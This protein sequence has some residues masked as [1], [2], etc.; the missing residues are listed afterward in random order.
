METNEN[1]DCPP[2]YTPLAMASRD[3]KRKLPGYAIPP[4][5]CGRNYTFGD[6]GAPLTRQPKLDS[7]ARES[8]DSGGWDSED[9]DGWDSEDSDAW[10]S[11]DDDAQNFQYADF[12]K[13]Q[14][15]DSQQPPGVNFQK[16]Q[17]AGPHG[18]QYIDTENPQD[19]GCSDPPRDDEALAR[20]RE[21]ELTKKRNE[22]LARKRNRD[23]FRIKRH[24]FSRFRTAIRD[25]DTE[26]VREMVESDGIISAR[27]LELDG[28][29]PLTNAIWFGQY[30]VVRAL[31]KNGAD[32]NEFGVVPDLDDFKDRHRTALQVAASR[33]NFVIARYLFQDCNADDS[34]IAPDGEL[35][36]R[37]AADRKYREIVNMLPVRRGGGQLRWKTK[38]AKAMK[39][40][41]KAAKKIGKFFKILLWEAPYTIL[42]WGPY[43]IGECVWKH[44]KGITD[45][46][47]VLLMEIPRLAWKGVKKLPEMVADLGGWLLKHTKNAPE[48]IKEVAKLYGKWLAKALVDLGRAATEIFKRLFSVLHIVVVAMLHFKDLTLRDVWNGFCML[49]RAVFVNLPK[50]VAKKLEALA[51]TTY[52][53]LKKALGFFGTVVAAILTFVLG[54]ITYIPEKLAKILKALGGPFAAG[55]HEVMVWYDPKW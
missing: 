16:P 1:P 10:H 2:A 13:P 22:N 47:L 44:R 35:A 49:A 27:A 40:A 55:F 50:T 52:E 53:A 21:E 54:V 19:G 9:A 5:R 11:Q 29:L 31:V 8:Q 6:I 20:E 18:P 14:D 26:T 3:P 48:K 36:L 4:V 7:E 30:D 12:Q 38:K 43:K 15:A 45:F 28:R 24:V 23:L 34:I 37:L 33:G 51:E 32:V 41:R 17:D 46:F 25:G 39:E 42:L